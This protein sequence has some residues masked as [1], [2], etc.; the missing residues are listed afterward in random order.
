[1]SVTLARGRCLKPSSWLTAHRKAGRVV[2]KSMHGFDSDQAGFE[3]RLPHV[4]AVL[5]AS[6]ARPGLLPCLRREL[7]L[8]HGRESLGGLRAVKQGACSAQRKCPVNTLSGS[9][10]LNFEWCHHHLLSLSK[11]QSGCEVRMFPICKCSKSVVSSLLSFSSMSAATHVF[12]VFRKQA[13][14]LAVL[15]N[16]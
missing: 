14:A 13:W 10:Y 15:T 1:M 3:S 5:P 6:L 7:L 16:T 8:S 9:F 4:V 12:L 11:I 2:L